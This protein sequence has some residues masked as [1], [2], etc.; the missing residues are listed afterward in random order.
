[1]PEQPEHTSSA[2]SFQLY[3]VEQSSPEKSCLNLVRQALKCYPIPY[4]S[5]TPTFPDEHRRAYLAG[6]HPYCHRGNAKG[7]EN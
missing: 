4:L 7:A 5:I 1:M 6:V 2:I 3:L